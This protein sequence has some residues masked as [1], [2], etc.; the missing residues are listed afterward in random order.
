MAP[1]NKL[2]G[3]C[4]SY[5]Q[6][7]GIDLYRSAVAAAAAFELPFDLPDLDRTETVAN[8]L[9]PPKSRDKTRSRLYRLTPPARV[10]LSALAQTFFDELGEF[11]AAAPVETRDR[12]LA[13]R[14]WD[15]VAVAADAVAECTDATVAPYLLRVALGMRARLR[16][17]APPRATAAAPLEQDFGGTDCFAAHLRAA[18]LAAAGADQL[19]AGVTAAVLAPFGEA[20]AV[21]LKSVAHFAA[22][23]QVV[24]PKFTVNETELLR[25]VG[26]C[27]PLLAGREAPPDVHAYLL[28]ALRAYQ[29]AALELKAAKKTVALAQAGVGAI[30]SRRAEQAAA[31]A[32]TPAAAA[33]TPAV[34][35]TPAPEPVAA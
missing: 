10:A 34:A 25:A 27:F 8:C 32:E 11:F 33:E 26:V 13:A 28:A 14:D 30:A 12:V 3:D 31:A 23:S 18:T 29:D 16:F 21:V 24:H 35:V 15:A 1:K 17:Y 2:T 5:V 7:Y 22:A 6:L 19:P 4:A 20:F 9:L